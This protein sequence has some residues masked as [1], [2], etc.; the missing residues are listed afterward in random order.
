MNWLFEG[1]WPI[2]I[3][4]LVVEA[5]L[6]IGLLR[7]G[8]VNLLWA[9]GGS[10][11]VFAALFVLERLIV[12]ESEQVSDTLHGVA[13]A[14]TDNDLPAVL[15]YISPDAAD[16]RQLASNSLRSIHVQQAKIGS[17]LAITIHE[18]AANPTAQANFTGRIQA[19]G[20]HGESLGHDTYVG[21]FRV[22]LIKRDDRW[23]V[24]TFE[25]PDIKHP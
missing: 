11:L 17:D 2:L 25:R 1:P 18:R 24:S 6:V 15:E 22:G 13:A 20:N 10:G 16:V 8:R 14:V 23:L 12:T 21:R 4:A 3:T 7:T 9:I 5:I 19:R